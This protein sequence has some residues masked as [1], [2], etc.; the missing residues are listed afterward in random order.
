MSD[1]KINNF[2][3]YNNYIN[4]KFDYPSL[5]SNINLSIDFSKLFFRY[6]SISSHDFLKLANNIFDS[7]QPI[8]KNYRH[9]KAYK[10]IDG[11]PYFFRF[12]FIFQQNYFLGTSLR[13]GHPDVNIIDFIEN[14]IPYNYAMSAVE[15]SIDIH[16]S[17]P[18]EL[19]RLIRTTAHIRWPGKNTPSSYATTYYLSNSRTSLT[20]GCYA[21]IKF[22]TPE[23]PFVRVELRARN[24]FYK[25]KNIEKIKTALS[26]KPSGVFK[27]L[28][29]SYVDLKA[30]LVKSKLSLDFETDNEE[31]N[32]IL[33]KFFG[34]IMN[35]SIFNDLESDT[36]VV[37][38]TGVKQ[39]VSSITKN[40]SSIYKEHEF[41]KIFF[42]S[43]E[44]KSFI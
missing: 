29:F 17:D 39:K 37:G 4:K 25:R 34:M 21:Y 5:I 7:V 6:D 1:K 27:N 20:S 12:S 9:F 24:H 30:L 8:H 15:Y 35:L 44:N 43:I 3:L 13:I 42:E 18:Y 36:G 2:K 10:F 28:T 31:N 19:F 11:N 40:S 16:G 26:L 32:M 41:H 38:L 22:N 33:N 23:K 14:N